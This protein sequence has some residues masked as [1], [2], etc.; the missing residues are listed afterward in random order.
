[1]L[2]KIMYYQNITRQEKRIQTGDILNDI[3]E[4][5]TAFDINRKTSY[6]MNNYL[7]K[8][9][10]LAQDPNQAPFLLPTYST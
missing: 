6:I 2:G 7:I 3:N 1:M 5:K 4:T 8:D 10:V 9:N